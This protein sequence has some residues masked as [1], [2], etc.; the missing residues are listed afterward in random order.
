MATYQKINSR[1]D[2]NYFEQRDILI[3]H[4]AEI[5]RSLMKKHKLRNVLDVGCGTGLLVKFLNDKGFRAY[6]CDNSKEALKKARAINTKKIIN[7]ASATKLPYPDGFFDL[8]TSISVIEHMSK[9]DAEKFIKEA[10]RVL[11]YSGFIFIVTP[12]YSTPIRLVQGKGWFGYCDPT[13]INYFTRHSLDKTLKDHGFNKNIFQFNL[14]YHDSINWEFPPFFS[15]F[16]KIIKIVAIYFFFSSPFSILR[17]SL[18]VFSKKV[19]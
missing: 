19:N 9:I 3:P 15:K 6:G 16:P 7:Q 14:K 5:V 13:H 2:K 1:Y 4:L 10:R 11:S 12:N 8:V 17:N 18:W